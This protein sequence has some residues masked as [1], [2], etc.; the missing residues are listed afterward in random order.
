MGNTDEME[1]DEPLRS[2]LAVIVDKNGKVLLVRRR[3][4]PLWVL[5]GGGVDKEES[6]LEAAKREVYEES[7]I[8]VALNRQVAAYFPVNRLSRPTDIFWGYPVGGRVSLSEETSGAGFFR[9]DCLPDS[10]F[11]IHAGWMREILAADRC[12]SRSLIEVNYQ[13]LLYYALRH[14][15]WTFKAVMARL[16]YPLNG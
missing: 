12:I 13:R 15:L 10:F 1:S 11:E 14:P 2:A 3:D 9:L 4:I 16:G 6:S 7:G 8:D 5:P